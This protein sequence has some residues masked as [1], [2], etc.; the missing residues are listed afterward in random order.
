VAQF[1]ATLFPEDE[2]EHWDKV[3]RQFRAPYWDWA[4]VTEE[5]KNVFPDDFAGQRNI[6][7]S[8]PNGVQ[9]I[10]NPLYSYNFQ[11]FNASIFPASPVSVSSLSRPVLT[12]LTP[13]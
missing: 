8:G 2:L 1:I 10:A 6:T 12:G 7:A 3:A 13:L 5:G 4:R 9:E 11:P